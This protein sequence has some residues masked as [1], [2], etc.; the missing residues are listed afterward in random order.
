MSDQISWWVELAIKPGQL[1]NFQTLTHEMVEATRRERGVLSYQRF[2]SDDGRIVHAFERYADSIAAVEH[3]RT[4]ERSF[5]IRFLQ[6]VDRI[7]FTVFGD[8]DEEL[9]SL[10][11]SFGA[12]YAKPFG[13]FAQGDP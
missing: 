2:I 4:F 7:R 5:S 1:E 11:D 8:P 3:L 13:G 12:T 9:K 6:M 10:L